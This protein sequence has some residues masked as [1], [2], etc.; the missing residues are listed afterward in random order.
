M[1]ANIK[2]IFYGWVDWDDLAWFLT[3]AFDKCT[4]HMAPLTMNLQ[5]LSL[6]LHS[7]VKGNVLQETQASILIWEI[8]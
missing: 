1:L 4:A 8:V 3:H 5:H 7:L 2:K 6:V